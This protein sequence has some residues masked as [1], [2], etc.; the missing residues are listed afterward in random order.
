[1]LETIERDLA[2]MDRPK[3]RGI[4]W[5]EYRFV[6]ALFVDIDSSTALLNT[7]GPEAY[8]TLLTG[9]HDR[10][11]YVIELHDGVIDQY[12]GDG[13]FCF[14][15]HGET[16]INGATRAIQAVLDLGEGVAQIDGQTVTYRVGLAT[17]HALFNDAQGAEKSKAVG[18]CINLAARLTDY[19][20]QGEFLVCPRT[21]AQAHRHF[22]FEEL[23]NLLLKG[24]SESQ[25]AYRLV[26]RYQIYGATQRMLSLSNSH[27]QGRDD[28]ISNLRS[29]AKKVRSGRSIRLSI[30][31][32]AGMGK[33]KLAQT[34]LDHPDHND[35]GKM[36]LYCR[37]ED[38][39]RDFGPVFTY[40]R[41]MSGCGVEDDLATQRTKLANLFST[42]WQLDETGIE[43]LLYLMGY[44]TD[45]APSED[46][47]ILRRW[48]FD[49]LKDVTSS[50][51]RSRKMLILLVEDAQ[52][53]DPSTAEFL[54]YLSTNSQDQ[55][56]FILSTQRGSRDDT[57]AL[58]ASDEQLF[59]QPLKQGDVKQLVTASAKDK[60]VSDD[61]FDWICD[62]AMGIPFY[63]HLLY[64]HVQDMDDP[65]R[66]IT[67]KDQG[68][69]G[70]FETRLDRLPQEAK[71]FI[72]TAS[73]LGRRFLPDMVL[74]VLDLDPQTLEDCLT[75][76]FDQQL[77][78]T[79]A[80]GR[81]V[82]FSHDLVQE[83][84]NNNLSTDLRIDLHRRAADVLLA[85]GAA[86]SNLARHYKQSGQAQPALDQ[87]KHAVASAFQLGALQ[88]AKQFV[89]DAY[90]CLNMVENPD[91]RLQEELFFRM[92]E[93]PLEMILGG[94]GNP[95]F[96]LALTRTIDVMARLDQTN[97]AIAPT[98][99]SGLHDWACGR[100]APAQ[101][102]AYQILR[103][104]PKSPEAVLAGNTLAGLVAWHKGENQS[105]KAHL[106]TVIAT[107]Q[108]DT[109][110]ALFP[111]FMMDFGVFSLFYSSLAAAILGEEK[112]AH[113]FAN[114]SLDLAQSHDIP[115]P[116]GFGL[117]A[118]T[119]NAVMQEDWS[120]VPEFA[121]KL[122]TLAQDHNFPEFMA[123]SQ[124]SSGLVAVQSTASHAQGLAQMTRAYERLKD[125]G[126][127]CWQGF[128]AG[129]LCDEMI[130]VGAVFSVEAILSEHITLCEQ[131][132]EGQFLPLL[133]LTQA[134]F[135]DAMD[136][137][138]A[139]HRMMEKAQSLA[140]DQG[141]VLWDRKIQDYYQ[142][143][144]Q[145]C[146]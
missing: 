72:Q 41:W 100:L 144:A 78:E 135:F 25:S 15:Y 75:A 52:W 6:T 143:R 53:I 60:P 42:A 38:G 24:F 133:Y 61:V 14:F 30:I 73:V 3:P 55:P 76:L 5:S 43:T 108:A 70:F 137:L 122:E 13:A 57:Q 119:L 126:F 94:P 80:D 112:S 20:N 54:A 145:A 131:N 96:G 118:K 97:E 11:R 98:Y 18:S 114:Q 130:K 89:L 65:K 67:T 44:D 138:A 111:K 82:A 95:R 48:L 51:F 132:G 74:E 34:F 49:T 125:I 22:E 32:Q 106:G 79:T 26:K 81:R 127:V 36:I 129:I 45:I 110:L 128:L 107:Y 8:Q 69:A 35:C 84:I 63:V 4:S 12:Q 21:K 141:A 104:Y 40:L 37:R 87:L 101:K 46:P 93:A 23:G 7:V 71:R 85:R 62:Q 109:H 140:G 16:T 10:L 102:I 139:A 86:P 90:A 31:G 99:N 146:D 115:H 56:L 120:A 88:E 105:A 39:S 9:F 142:I 124:F 68:F 113:A 27:L 58:F 77:I 29:V 66:D 91:I 116:L 121:G 1:M 50:A 28:D 59:L 92:I 117:L 136:Q 83:T 17:G 134:K 33:S 19:G 47:S 64:Q 123:L 103:D 2:A